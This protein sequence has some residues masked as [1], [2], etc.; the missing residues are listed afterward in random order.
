[1]R[2]NGIARYGTGYPRWRRDAI[3]RFAG[4][5]ANSPSEKWITAGFH[6]QQVHRNV[7]RYPGLQKNNE[8][9]AKIA[10][11]IACE[12]FPPTAGLIPLR[13]CPAMPFVL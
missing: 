2:L 12:R 8:E 6:S 4:S 9:K 7:L 1:M 11:G 5:G 3:K 13:L 10:E